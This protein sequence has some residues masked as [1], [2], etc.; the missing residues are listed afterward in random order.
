MTLWLFK[1]R[2]SLSAQYCPLWEQAN[3]NLWT[4]GGRLSNECLDVGLNGTFRFILHYGKL[5]LGREFSNTFPR[6]NKRKFS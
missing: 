1:T 4:N 3:Y 2:L 6:V 5:A